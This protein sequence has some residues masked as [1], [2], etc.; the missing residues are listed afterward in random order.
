VDFYG[1][2]TDN[3]GRIAEMSEVP[4]EVR[5]FTD[6][7]NAVGNT[8]KA[9]TKGYAIGSAATTTAMGRWP[10]GM[11]VTSIVRDSVLEP[12]RYR[13][14]AIYA[15]PAVQSEPVG[16]EP[17]TLT[18]TSSGAYRV[19]QVVPVLYDPTDPRRAVINNVGNLWVGSGLAMTGGA[20]ILLLSL[21]GHPLAM[22]AVVFLSLVA[23]ALNARVAAGRPAAPQ[24][25]LPLE[26]R[27]WFWAFKRA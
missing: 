9:V 7:L 11:T 10:T 14:R 5:T 4:H 15:H 25:R 19:G 3:V 12:P 8:T 1:P 17:I 20:A 18:H 6:A 24:D 27:I 2:I 22:G 13:S 26:F 16:G 21:W 23:A